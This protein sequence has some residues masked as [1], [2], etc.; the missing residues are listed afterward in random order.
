MFSGTQ[1]VH[2]VVY[3]ERSINKSWTR[4]FRVLWDKTSTLHINAHKLRKPRKSLYKHSVICS[5]IYHFTSLITYNVSSRTLSQSSSARRHLVTVEC[6]NSGRAT[7]FLQDSSITTLGLS[8]RSTS[9]SCFL[10]CDAT[11]NADYAKTSVRL[12]VT[13]RYS[14]ETAKHSSNFSLSSSHTVLVELY[15]STSNANSSSRTRA[16]LLVTLTVA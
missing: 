12:S 16:A 6:N 7:D 3:Y 9:T 4:T 1:H 13:C 15:T 2:T 8:G 10:P 5:D 14:V 11:D